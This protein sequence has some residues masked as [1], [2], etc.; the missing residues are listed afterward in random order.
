M[1]E[2]K[3]GKCANSGKVLASHGR[4]ATGAYYQ[5]YEDCS[6]C[7]LVATISPEL[8]AFLEAL[9][10][11]RAVSAIIENPSMQYPHAAVAEAIDR[12]RLALK[13]IYPPWRMIT[14]ETVRCYGNG[15]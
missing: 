10:A 14:S 11:M 1:M 2:Q 5:E 6:A 13:E 12:A 7:V 4:D 9:A 8:T 15:R 3:C